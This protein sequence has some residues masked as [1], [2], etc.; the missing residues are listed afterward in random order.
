MSRSG[1]DVPNGPMAELLAR[2]AIFL[3]AVHI[4]KLKGAS[5]AWADRV[6][7]RMRDALTR[8]YAGR[9]RWVRPH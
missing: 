1:R 4:C 8:E 3:E 2:W 5:E 7:R 6:T 9:A